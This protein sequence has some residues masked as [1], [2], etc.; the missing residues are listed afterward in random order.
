MRKLSER[1]FDTIVQDVAASVYGQ[2]V[3]KFSVSG[4]SVEATYRTRSRKGTW[5]ADFTFNAENGH[6]RYSCPYR[7]AGSPRTFGDEI[8]RRIREAVAD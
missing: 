3:E 2:A 5:V 7:S 6:Y 4:F 1:E 8:G